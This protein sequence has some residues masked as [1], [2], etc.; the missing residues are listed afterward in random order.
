MSW[1]SSERHPHSVWE[2]WPTDGAPAS[3]RPGASASGDAGAP[4][5]PSS[6]V[7]EW[8]GRDTEPETPTAG[9]TSSGAA[10]DPAASPVPRPAAGAVTSSPTDSEAQPGRLRALTGALT[11]L[12]W[13]TALVLGL[14]ATR[15]APVLLTWGDAVAAVL[16][17]A[18][19]GLL[20][21]MVPRLDRSPWPF[22]LV[23]VT[24]L[25]LVVGAASLI[26]GV[27]LAVP[28]LVAWLLVGG[29]LVGGVLMWGFF[30]QLH[31]KVGLLQ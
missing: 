3:P 26:K 12:W 24:L 29:L 27:L 16:L 11:G 19:S 10:V 22:S 7:A 8:F 15:Q 14:R 21:S 2:D 4:Y 1:S 23:F 31:P 25:V 17:L 13:L 30:V 18:G 9:Q 6:P 28:V 5:S 20:L